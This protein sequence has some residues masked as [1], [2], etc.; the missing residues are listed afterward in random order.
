MTLF[1]SLELSMIWRLIL[2][3]LVLFLLA[4]PPKFVG[5]AN[6]ELPTSQA[7]TVESRA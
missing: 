2:A 7:V 6:I 1:I 4:Q 5:E 3:G